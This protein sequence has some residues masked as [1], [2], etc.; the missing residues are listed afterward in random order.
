MIV[1]VCLSLSLLV[2]N[3]ELTESKFRTC[4]TKGRG[5]RL[6]RLPLWAWIL[7]AATGSALLLGLIGGIAVC[8]RKGKK[9][10]SRPKRTL[11]EPRPTDVQGKYRSA[12]EAW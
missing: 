8:A 12:K 1:H 4:P 11:P 10:D 2:G 6:R 3:A 7:I 5:G 9:G